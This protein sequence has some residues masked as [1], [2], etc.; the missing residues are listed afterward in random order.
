M[1]IYIY[2]YNIYIYIYIYYG[3]EIFLTL[4]TCFHPETYLVNNLQFCN[5]HIKGTIVSHNCR[6]DFS[7]LLN[8]ISISKEK[9]MRT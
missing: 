5:G 4:G 6:L 2:K 7:A 3:E 8:T 9:A 1:Y